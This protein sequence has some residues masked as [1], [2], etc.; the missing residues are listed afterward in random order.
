MVMSD[1]EKQQQ[2][3]QN[4]QNTFNFDIQLESGQV[5]TESAYFKYIQ[6][7]LAERIKFF[8]NTDMDKLLQAL[9]RIDVNDAMTDQ[10]FNLGEVNKVAMKLAELI[11]VRQLQKLDYSRKFH[12]ALGGE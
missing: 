1:K 4:L 11:I 6:K 2:L 12:Q 9:Y 3:V 10:A 5:D 8:I 7:K